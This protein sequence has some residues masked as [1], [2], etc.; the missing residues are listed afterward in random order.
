MRRLIDTNAL[1]S[2]NRIDVSYLLTSNTE[3]WGTLNMHDLCDKSLI[4]HPL[5][6]KMISCLSDIIRTITRKF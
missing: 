4:M 2:V 5:G 6:T 3:V 1:T